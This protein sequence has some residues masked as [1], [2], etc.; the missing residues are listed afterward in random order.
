M[1]FLLP[2]VLNFQ[3]GRKPKIEKV[4]LIFLKYSLKMDA[5]WPQRK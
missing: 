5:V 1:L 3:K 4:Y 2:Y